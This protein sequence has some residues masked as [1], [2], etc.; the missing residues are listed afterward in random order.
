MIAS[1]VSAPRARATETR[2]CPSRTAYP[3]PTGAT[4]IGGRTAPRCSA[5]QTRSQRTRA[6]GAGR[7]SLSNCAARL[8]SS[9]PLIASSGI[10]RIPPAAVARA[11]ARS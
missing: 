5:S 3:S 2:W 1:I 10:S 7:K 9:V 8:G 11:A 6:S 4:L